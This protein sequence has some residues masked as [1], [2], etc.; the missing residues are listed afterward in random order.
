MVM[1]SIDIAKPPIIKTARF[2]SFRTDIKLRVFESELNIKN[3]F[4]IIKAENEMALI[5]GSLCPS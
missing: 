5:S 4:P 1:I 2:R 3:I